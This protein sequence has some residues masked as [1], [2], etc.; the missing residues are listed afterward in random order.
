MLLNSRPFTERIRVFERAIKNMNINCI[1]EMF[2]AFITT[3]VKEC[4]GVRRIHLDK[5]QVNKT[6]PKKGSL[7]VTVRFKNVL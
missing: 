4:G 6:F 7:I 2:N 3:L 5:S 1:A